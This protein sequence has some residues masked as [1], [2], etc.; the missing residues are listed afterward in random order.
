M[1]KLSVSQECIA[2]GNCIMATELIIEQPNGKAVPK[3]AGI[4]SDEE[5]RQIQSVVDACPVKAICLE[6][7]MD[8]VS[9]TEKLNR[10]KQELS[11]LAEYQIERPTVEALSCKKE[12]LQVAMPTAGLRSK[13]SYTSYEK[14]QRDGLRTFNQIVHSQKRVLAQSALIQYKK[15]FLD[16][17]TRYEENESSYYFVENKKIENQLQGFAKAVQEVF[18]NEVKLP[19]E[20]L[21][22]KVVP[23]ELDLFGRG[24]VCFEDTRACS[25]AL[26]NVE[27][28]DWYETYVNTDEKELSSRSLYCY[29]L[30]EAV[31]TISDHILDGCM[32]GIRDEAQG[33]VKE[34]L[35]WHQGN[36]TKA[37]REKVAIINKAI[38]NYE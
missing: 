26:E 2:C 17:Y 34:V 23:K 4:L 14:A 16:K 1:Q 18:S 11:K 38:N 7:I 29:D 30:Q 33:F 5:A 19:A 21:I 6:K 35:D 3:E 10:I 20:A 28:L 15:L 24:V 12:Q 8:G 13:F 36:V 31:D 37:L 9:Q 25:T 22:F 27:N 32:E